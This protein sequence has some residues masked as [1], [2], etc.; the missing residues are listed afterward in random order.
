MILC[1]LRGRRFLEYV[2]NRARVWQQVLKFRAAAFTG[3]HK[4]SHHNGMLKEGVDV[5]VCTPGRLRQLLEGSLLS[6]DLCQV[7]LLAHPHSMHLHATAPLHM[8]ETCCIMDWK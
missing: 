8:H 5:A 1:F 4:M 6:L 3:G 7:L 2:R